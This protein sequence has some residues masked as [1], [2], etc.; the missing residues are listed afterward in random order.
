MDEKRVLWNAMD[1]IENRPALSRWNP[2]YEA[3][4]EAFMKE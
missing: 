2:A 4:F 3:Q 1:L